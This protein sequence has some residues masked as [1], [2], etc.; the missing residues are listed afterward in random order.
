[1][2]A[3][4]V[5]VAVSMMVTACGST[6][7]VKTS[8]TGRVVE[9][10]KDAAQDVYFTVSG[11]MSASGCGSGGYT[12]MRVG[13]QVEVMNDKKDLL[14]VGSLTK[15]TG[16]CRFEFSVPKVRKGQKLYGVHIG[17]SNRGV[18]WHSETEA[19]QGFYLTLG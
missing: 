2:K 18:I 12:D 7:M 13:A 16:Y 10:A 1:M 15:A 3:A 5:M 4:A 6:E 19:L 11:T 9:V 8:S 17:N 14:G